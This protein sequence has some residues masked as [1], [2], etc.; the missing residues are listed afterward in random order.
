MQLLYLLLLAGLARPAPP[1]ILLLLADDLGYNDVSWNS[2]PVVTPN[3]ANLAREGVILKQFYS[4][5]PQYSRNL[6]YSEALHCSPAV[7]P[8]EPPSSLAAILTTL[9]SRY[10]GYC[11]PSYILLSCFR[12]HTLLLCY[13]VCVRVARKHWTIPAD[14]SGHH[15]SHPAWAPPGEGLQ[16]N[17]QH[18]SNSIFQMS[19]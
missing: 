13:V 5:V 17:I 12:R 10:I 8:A 16:V 18:T 4:Q 1:N 6:D 2:G 11:S 15:L 7:P 3:L 14:R 19:F 9:V